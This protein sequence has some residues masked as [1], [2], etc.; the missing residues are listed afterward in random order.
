MKAAELI[1]IVE[2]RPL[3]ECGGEAQT[4]I[5]YGFACDL[6]SDALALIQNSDATVLLTGL[7][8][9]QSLR[10]AEMLDIRMVVYVRAKQLSRQDLELA[11]QMGISIYSTALTMYEACGR[12]YEH[13]LPS[14]VI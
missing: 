10:T 14:L 7:A 11:R 6:M 4:E 12:L 2:A 8:N 1:R 5:C 3:I 13:G 9:A